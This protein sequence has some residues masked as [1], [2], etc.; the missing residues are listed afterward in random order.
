MCY[1]VNASDLLKKKIKGKGM[2]TVWEGQRDS[3]S[4]QSYCR[5]VTQTEWDHE[6]N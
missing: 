1:L 3:L 5:L 2:L 4:F 6:L